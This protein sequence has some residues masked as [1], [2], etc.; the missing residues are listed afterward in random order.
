VRGEVN[1]FA[2]GD[3]AAAR[4]CAAQEIMSIHCVEARGPMASI[5][6][7]VF[8]TQSLCL[9]K[10]PGAA[11]KHDRACNWSW[12]WPG[13]IEPFRLWK[14]DTSCPRACRRRHK[15]VWCFAFFSRTGRSRVEF[16][17]QCRSRASALLR[18]TSTARSLW[19]RTLSAIGDS[20]SAWRHQ[21]LCEVRL[22]DE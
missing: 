8:H 6:D 4:D 18:R 16:L 10:K 20:G 13:L 9:R 7:Q 2:A 12:S 5:T 21:L 3:T 22:R 15:A 14:K 19:F 11:R 1:H 17:A